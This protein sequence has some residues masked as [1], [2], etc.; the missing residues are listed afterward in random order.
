MFNEI[1][2]LTVVRTS[3]AA[4]FGALNR[5]AGQYKGCDNRKHQK[6][7]QTFYPMPDDVESG[8]FYKT[9]VQPPNSF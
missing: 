3:F 9:H 4:F 7:D 2:P 8:S 6:Q 5:N 1:F